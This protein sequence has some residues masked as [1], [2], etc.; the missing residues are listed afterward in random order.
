M[1]VDVYVNS[2]LRN[3]KLVLQSF[4][5]ETITLRFSNNTTDYIETITDESGGITVTGY[6]IFGELSLY[7]ESS[8]APELSPTLFTIPSGKDYIVSEFVGLVGSYE[9]ILTTPVYRVESGT[10]KE[11]EAYKYVNADW[12]KISSKNTKR[13]VK[14]S[15]Y[16]FSLSGV[17]TLYSFDNGDN[18]VGFSSN[19]K[20][21]I[22]GNTYQ[23]KFRITTSGVQTGKIIIRSEKFG[24]FFEKDLSVQGMASSENIILTDDMDDL[25]VSYKAAVGNFIFGVSGLDSSTPGLTR[26][27]DCANFTYSKN[28]TTGLITTDFDEYFNF[29]RVS[30]K[31]GNIFVRIPK[32]YKQ[33]TAG[34]TL[35]I[36]NY[37][38]D[39]TYSIY[40]C[41]KNETG[42]EL[43]YF[44]FGAYKASLWTL[45]DKK[46][47]YNLYPAP[48]LAISK[49]KSCIRVYGS[50]PEMP[51]VS[52]VRSKV[53][54]Y[55]DN[56]FLYF[57]RDIRSLSLIQDIF[58]ITFGTR[59]MSEVIG[60][61]FA[62]IQNADH[63][64]TVTGSGGFTQ[65][66]NGATDKIQND[67]LTSP[68]SCCGLDPDTHTFKLF[69]IEDL[70]GT[71]LEYIDGIY[72][73]KNNYV[74]ISEKPSTNKASSDLTPTFTLGYKFFSN[75]TVVRESYVIKKL[76]H[77]PN[78]PGYNLPTASVSVSDTSQYYVNYADV[79]TA[80]PRTFLVGF[81]PSGTNTNK[82]FGM[83][84]IESDTTGPWETSETHGTPSWCTRIMRQ[85]V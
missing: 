68:K 67:L 21:T 66:L 23:V 73:D 72:R 84:Y 2:N 50:S 27:D 32:L 41:F 81:N 7:S 9:N 52:K 63:A 6:G 61:E 25:D 35:K 78:H 59:D 49:P 26:T 13:N 28:E 1:A 70:V 56:E 3:S 77:D 53:S 42:E 33:Y 46:A 31:N 4:D 16:D 80:T 5:T 76:G 24:L 82:R 22:L 85:H 47:G 37:K 15:R 55:S 62:T 57:M 48:T 17:Q 12:C 60:T 20:N 10:W 43:D 54:A 8:P 45:G 29:D 71:C 79:S 18:W 75:S 34:D 36:A 14:V 83:F 39:D 74:Y 30:D 40:P 38:V 11:Q 65:G 51:M 44:D 58:M 64:M 69:G 19:D